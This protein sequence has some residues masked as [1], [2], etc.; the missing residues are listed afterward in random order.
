[1]SVH[2]FAYELNNDIDDTFCRLFQNNQY[3]LDGPVDMDVIW[4]LKLQLIILIINSLFM[5]IYCNGDEF[6]REPFVQY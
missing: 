1:M 4:L 6:R 5:I 3:R 2:L